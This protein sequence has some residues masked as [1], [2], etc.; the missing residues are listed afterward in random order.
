[1]GGSGNLQDDPVGSGG[2]RGVS[3]EPDFRA[4]FVPEAG[5]APRT[6]H[7]FAPTG[8][9]ALAGGP[10]TPSTGPSYLLSVT[11]LGG[12]GAAHWSGGQ[13]VNVG[14]AV[15]A[16]AAGAVGVVVAVVVG[17]VVAVVLLPPAV[18]RPIESLA[19]LV[20]HMPPSG[21]AAIPVG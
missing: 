18:I 6:E 7:W 19:K 12:A 15:V 14:W 1:M 4:L 3:D 16:C 10:S 5:S 21:P 9:R 13:P 20:N 2:R 8:A 11:R 17:V